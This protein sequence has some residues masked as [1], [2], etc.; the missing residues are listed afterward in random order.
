MHD[1]S[2]TTMKYAAAWLA[3]EPGF[4]VKLKYSA[5]WGPTRRSIEAIWQIRS[6]CPKQVEPASLLP[7]LKHPVE[8]AN[9]VK[10]CPRFESLRRNTLRDIL[11]SPNVVAI[12]ATESR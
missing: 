4:A 6:M 7:R 10:H 1:G 12:V 8:A 5:R 3:L 2:N 11:P 9:R